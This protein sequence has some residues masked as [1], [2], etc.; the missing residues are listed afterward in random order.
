MQDVRVGPNTAWS[1][2]AYLS[3]SSRNELVALAGLPCNR[4]SGKYNANGE[5]SGR[6]KVRKTLY[7]AAQSAAQ[8]NPHI[9]ALHQGWG[10]E[11]IQPT[12]P[13]WNMTYE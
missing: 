13:R 3:E 8:H 10:H 2:L 7:M 5:S 12:C 9:K 11:A 6:A 4:D 1:I